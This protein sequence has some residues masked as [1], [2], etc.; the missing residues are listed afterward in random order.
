MCP[1][2][3]T[4]PTV[5]EPDRDA[6][7]VVSPFGARGG[8]SG[9]QDADNLGWKLALVLRNQ[10]PA[11]LLETY[12]AERHAA[13]KMNLEVASRTARFLAPQS[14]AERTL[15]RPIHPPLRRVR[16]RCLARSDGSERAHALARSSAGS[17]GRAH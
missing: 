2:K 14:E 17:H 10:A 7:H 1:H 9:I 15:R 11:H 12:D 16:R 6:A 4:C 3:P 5:D 8:N 13:A